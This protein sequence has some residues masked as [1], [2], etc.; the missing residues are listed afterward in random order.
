MKTWGQ[1]DGGPTFSPGVGAVEKERSLYAA[2]WQEAKVQRNQ[3][4]REKGGKNGERQ[5]NKRRKK[6]LMKQMSKQE[7]F[8]Q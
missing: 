7:D 5:Q 3:G 6:E 4:K 1:G 2:A 8:L